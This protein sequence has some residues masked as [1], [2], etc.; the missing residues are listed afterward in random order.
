MQPLAVIT[1]IMLGTS[2]AIAIGLSV[3]LLLFFILADEHPRLAAEFDPLLD[4][5]AIF[6]VLTMLCATSF[7]GTVR[8]RPWRWIAQ[9]GMWVGIVLTVLYYLP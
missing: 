4:S 9:S 6:V 3:V 1:G 8:S 5:T 7:F 2:A